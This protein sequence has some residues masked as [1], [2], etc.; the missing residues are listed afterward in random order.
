MSTPP[1]WAHLASKEDV[2]RL[3][4]HAALVLG[5]GANSI[6]GFLNRHFETDLFTR[7]M[8]SGMAL[9]DRIEI[10]ARGYG[11]RRPYR[12]VLKPRVIDDNYKPPE[13]AIHI[14]DIEDGQC[15]YVIF[16]GIDEPITYNRSF[17]CGLTTSEGRIYCDEHHD[18]CHSGSY[19]PRG[20]AASDLAQVV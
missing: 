2:A 3:I 19:S 18:E 20:D 7:N 6:T 16:P 11:R 4:R 8:V 5:L 10:P 12:L 15:R 1:I 13:G 14:K 9:R 17:C